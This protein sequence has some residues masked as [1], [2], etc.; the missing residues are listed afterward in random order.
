MSSVFVVF[1]YPIRNDWNRQR[2]AKKYISWI[3][4]SWCDGIWKLSQKQFLGKFHKRV[5]G[6]I[7]CLELKL[8]TK[9]IIPHQNNPFLFEKNKNIVFLR[10]YD[11]KKIIK[12]NIFNVSIFE[13]NM[14][15]VF[16]KIFFFLWKILI[17]E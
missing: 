11:F 14:L 1:L 5:T 7:P 10:K 9:S 8:K 17:Y 12:F 3:E 16:L 2:N 15:V 6:V 4:T 13:S